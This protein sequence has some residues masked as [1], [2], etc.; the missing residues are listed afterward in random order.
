M[1]DSAVGVFSEYG[2]HHASMDHIAAR[3]G[4]SKPM[5]YA[6]FGSKEELFV[7]CVHRE[8]TRLME[9]L[10]NAV[11]PDLP[12]DEQLWR[13]LRAFFAFVAAHREAW[14]VLYRQ[15]RGQEPF[16]AEVTQ[17]RTRMVD[18]VASLLARVIAAGG[19]RYRTEDVTS[20]AYALV[21]AGESLADWVVDHAEES[22]D[23]T[24]NRLM[25]FV[26][27]GAGELLRGAT[28]RSRTATG[29][30]G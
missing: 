19:R 16:A 3:A 15:A 26:W 2:F 8:G 27:L 12:P 28:W 1:L 29:S 20:M 17:M 9:A 30:A 7:A 14:S 6:Y 21:G 25:N 22:S 11:G 23:E 13:G 18:V 5:V 24:A 4:I 10:I